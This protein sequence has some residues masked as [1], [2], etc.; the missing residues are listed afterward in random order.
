MHLGVSLFEFIIVLVL[1]VPRFEKLCHQIN[2]LPLSL[3]SP[4]GAPIMQ[5]LVHL[6][7]SGKALRLSLLLFNLFLLLLL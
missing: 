7:M 1:W 3:S 6:M 2:I 4:S 5:I